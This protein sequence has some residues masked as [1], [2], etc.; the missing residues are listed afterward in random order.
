M[1]A[2]HVCPV[3]GGGGGGPYPSA[4]LGN[5]FSTIMIGLLYAGHTLCSV[6]V[7]VVW[8]MTQKAFIT[9]KLIWQANGNAEQAQRERGEE[10]VKRQIR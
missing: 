9:R 1:S 2:S 6:F 8:L 4:L 7:F 10:E 3:G 5:F